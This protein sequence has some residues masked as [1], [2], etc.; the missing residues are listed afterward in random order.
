MPNT[1]KISPMSAPTVWSDQDSSAVM[2]EI[3][4]KIAKEM[5]MKCAACRRYSAH[6]SPSTPDSGLM[7][8][9]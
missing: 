1:L 9:W 7:P 2:T 8:P 6:A 4:R 5:R 3:T